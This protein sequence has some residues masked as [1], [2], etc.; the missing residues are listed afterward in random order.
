M[1][2]SK[3]WHLVKVRMYPM[4]VRRD[5]YYDSLSVD[6]SHQDKRIL[7]IGFEDGYIQC[8]NDLG[9]KPKD[10]PKGSRGQ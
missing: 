8:L 1:K 9:I 2:I 10:H 7:A 6:L 4:Y 5:R 3:R